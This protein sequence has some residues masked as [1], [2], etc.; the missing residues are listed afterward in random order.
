MSLPIYS[1]VMGFTKVTVML[2]MVKNDRLG[3]LTTCGG[4]PTHRENTGS[5]GSPAP[6]SVNSICVLTVCT[7][8]FFF[9]FHRNSTAPWRLK[10]VFA[11]LR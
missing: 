8:T 11:T 10:Q 5:G 7:H 3:R 1:A 2:R 9:Q 4:A 6:N